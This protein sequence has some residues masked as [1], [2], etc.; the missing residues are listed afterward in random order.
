VK[1]VAITQ[2]VDQ[3]AGRAER[4]DALDANWSKLLRACGCLAVPMPNDA[5]SALALW[6][7]A[8]CEGLILSGGNDLVVYGGDAPERDDTEAQ[9]LELASTHG[10]PVL[11]VCRGMQFLVTQSGG[12]L[13]RVEDRVAVRHRLDNGREVDSCHDWVAQGCP[14]GWTP[15]ALSAGGVL[16]MMRHRHARWL[17]IMW[18]P[19]RNSP[20]A[21][22]DIELIED[23]FNA[24]QS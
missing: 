2:R 8:H 13:H 20:F 4:R 21:A 24:T 9:L 23:W 19:E 5:Q 14:P 17:G 22:E 15:L 7:T 10:V 12:K 6:F 1:T 18:H 3:L 11:G 16:E